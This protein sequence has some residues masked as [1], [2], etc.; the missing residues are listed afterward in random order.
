LLKVAHDGQS[1]QI[2]KLW[3]NF[4]GFST[5]LAKEHTTLPSSCCS[6][7]KLV[8]FR[9]LDILNLVVR[10]TPFKLL[11]VGIGYYN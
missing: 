1:T 2:A 5:V 7:V 6:F 8:L 10:V 3:L 9:S 4:T 11:E